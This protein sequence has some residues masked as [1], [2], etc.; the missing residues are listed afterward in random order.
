MTKQT[1]ETI[2]TTQLETTTG[3]ITARWL[4]NHPYAAAGFLDH[5]PR[6]EAAFS[7]NHPWAYNRI[8]T[9]AG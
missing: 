2:A 4:A 5:H 9:L 6:I 7:A 8:R 1:F 3:G